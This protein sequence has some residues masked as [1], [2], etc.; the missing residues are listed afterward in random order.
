VTSGTLAGR[1]ADDGLTAP[2]RI[3]RAAIAELVLHGAGALSMHEVADRAGVS[4]G[5]IH[6]HY[7][8]K[9]AVLA[10][11]AERLG[12]RISARGHRALAAATPRSIVADLRAWMAVELQLGEWRAL[13]SLGEWLAPAVQDAA[14]DALDARRTMTTE[15]S[16]TMFERLGIRPRIAPEQAGDLLVALVSGLAVESGGGDPAAAFDV[17]VLALIGLEE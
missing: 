2:E 1:E 5:L 15:M 13:I 7:H 9:D 16:I 4:K 17:L 6:Y 8:D 3:L 10:R 12:E 11:A 14:R